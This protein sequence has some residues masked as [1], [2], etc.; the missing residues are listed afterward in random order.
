MTSGQ[1]AGN[2]SS[3]HGL[4]SFG[5]FNDALDQWWVGSY[6][7][8]D[9]VDQEDKDSVLFTSGFIGQIFQA[10]LTWEIAISTI[11]S[12]GFS[13]TGTNTDV[14]YFLALNLNGVNHFVG[15]FT[16]STKPLAISGRI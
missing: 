16:K 4:Q 13:W 2:I 10:V 7:G 11:T 3:A 12:D 15:N 6:Q 5:V 8:N 9:G 1:A 14:F